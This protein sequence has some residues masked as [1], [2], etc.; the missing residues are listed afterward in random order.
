MQTS[1]TWGWAVLCIV[2][3]AGRPRG[4]TLTADYDNGLQTETPS[5]YKTE[6]RETYIYKI[7]VW[8]THKW[9]LYYVVKWRWFVR[10][11]VNSDSAD[12]SVAYS[13]SIHLC[14]SRARI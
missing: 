11:M 4:T 6:G 14:S 1:C 7:L 5:K 2:I 3:S 9:I 12:L 8:I 13:L 10:R